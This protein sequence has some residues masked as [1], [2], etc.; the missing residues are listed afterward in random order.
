MKDF[1]K[2]TCG[3]PPSPSCLH[4]DLI[5]LSVRVDPALRPT[6]REMMDHPWIVR[7][8]KQEVPMERWI[9]EVW[10]WPKP[11]RKSKDS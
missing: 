2:E 7:V 8:M 4:L 5:T 9:R 1:I 6:P 3:L 11:N 10:G